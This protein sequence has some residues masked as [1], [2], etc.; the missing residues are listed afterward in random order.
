MRRQSH[1]EITARAFTLVELMVV[2]AIIATLALMAVPRFNNALGPRRAEMAAN[3]VAADL[4]YAR[5]HARMTATTVAVRFEATNSAYT[6]VGV[7]DPDHPTQTYIVKLGD[8]PYRAALGS[9]DLGGD[10]NL[11]FDGWGDA[12][13]R[14]AI[15]VTTTAAEY[16]V[17]LERYA[18]HAA[19]SRTR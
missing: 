19:V 14:A 4:D 1:A 12:D 7:A 10:T 9:I 15:A 13:T 3:R 11:I 8:D 6:L 17:T 16:L 2:M 5:R 18:P